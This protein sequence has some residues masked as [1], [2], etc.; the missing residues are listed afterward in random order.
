[1]NNPV[2]EPIRMKAIIQCL[3]IKH[4]N[5]QSTNEAIHENKTCYV[6]LK[7]RINSLNK[8]ILDVFFDVAP[9]YRLPG[10]FISFHINGSGTSYSAK[11]NHWEW[12]ACPLGIIDIGEQKT[13]LCLEDWVG[14]SPY[15]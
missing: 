4:K 10:N 6:Y 11:V 5:V 12:A 15:L 2:G 3:S 9:K 13:F 7:V 1:M 14:E 8:N